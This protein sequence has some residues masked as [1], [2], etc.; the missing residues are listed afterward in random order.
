MMNYP[1]VLMCVVGPRPWQE[2]FQLAL[3]ETDREKLHRLVREAEVEMFLRREELG[4]PVE[5]REEFSTIAVA[6]EAL[7]SIIAHQ[8]G[9]PKPS[10]WSGNRDLADTA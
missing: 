1:E 9:G 2:V 8:L 6:T 4:N 7:R 10:V 3:N 5:D